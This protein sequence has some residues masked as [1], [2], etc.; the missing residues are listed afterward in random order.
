W[1]QVPSSS[2]LFLFVGNLRRSLLLLHCWAMTLVFTL[3]LGLHLFLSGAEAQ[4]VTQPDGHITV[5]E[6]APLELRCS[7]SYGGAIYL[8]WYVQYPNQGLLNILKYVTGTTLV[9]G[10]KGFKA[11]FRKNETSF[12]LRKLSAHWSDSAVYFCALSPVF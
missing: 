1:L 11:E 9:T 5:S 6:G 8:F 7:Y 2:D 12:H 4:S 10:I 3:A